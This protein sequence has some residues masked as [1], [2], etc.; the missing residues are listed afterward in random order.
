[1]E[2]ELK[3]NADRFL[4]F[5]EV[6]DN[7]RPKCPEKVKE[8]ILKYLGNNPSDVVDLGCGTGLSTVI[9]SEISNKVIG[10]E[11]SNDMIKIAREKSVDLDNVIFMSAFSDN[12]EFEM[13][14]SYRMCIGIK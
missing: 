8:I 14:F 3:L 10:I 11:P 13:D 12:T 9:W 4:G 2:K 1:M 7:S 5:A 6:Y